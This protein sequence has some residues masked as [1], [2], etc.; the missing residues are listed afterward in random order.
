MESSKLEQLRALMQEA[1]ETGQLESAL[2]ASSVFPVPQRPSR[3]N[4]PLADFNRMVAAMPKEIQQPIIPKAKSLAPSVLGSVAA[5]SNAPPLVSTATTNP[6]TTQGINPMSLAHER[7]KGIP[8][9]EE[10]AKSQVKAA[11]YRNEPSGRQ[12]MEQ[13]KQMEQLSQP[14]HQQPVAS[15]TAAPPKSPGHVAAGYVSTKRNKKE[16]PVRRPVNILLNEAIPEGEEED[17]SSQMPLR[18]EGAMTDASKR[19]RSPASSMFEERLME[20]DNDDWEHVEGPPGSLVDTVYAPILF[21]SWISN[22]GAL[23]TMSKISA[24]GCSY[25]DGQHPY[26][27]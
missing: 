11:L 18:T 20:F 25:G 24:R 19:Q 10:A 5:S 12:T 23:W 16:G 7:G 8:S 22:W 27:T 15:V 9:A 26:S 13:W 17:V 6:T 21:Y 4:V 1:R 3:Q 14:Q 2:A